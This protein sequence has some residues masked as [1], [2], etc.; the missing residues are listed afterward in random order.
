MKSKTFLVLL[1]VCVVLALASLVVF[2]SDD[3]GTATTPEGADFFA[4]LPVNDVTGLTLSGP[5]GEVALA[6][7]GTVW[8][9]ENRYGYPADFDD[10]RAFILKLRDL[11]VGRAF[12]ADADSRRRLSLLPPDAEGADADHRGTRV[13][14]QT[15]DSGP[16][17]DLIIGA[18]RETDAGSGGHYLRRADG[19][20]V[21]LVDESFQ[22]LELDP[23]QWLAPDL[24]DISAARVRRVTCLNAATGQ[25]L[26]RIERPEKG[27]PPVFVDPA[28][29]DRTVATSKVTNLFSALDNLTLED[30]ANP[31]TEAREMGL[32]T[33]ICHEFWLF[34]GTT[35]TVCKGR[36]LPDEENQ[37]Y[38][39]ATAG[40]RAP[41]EP[42]PAPESD[43]EA[44]D[45]ADAEAAPADGET[46]EAAAEETEDAPDPAQVA[47]E[48]EQKNEALSK[49]TF[50][51]PKWKVG[52]LVTDV[53]EFFET[54]EA[55]QP[56]TPPDP[57]PATPPVED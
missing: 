56:P 41:P 15:S 44:S 46:A 11:N 26:Y 37:H 16:A 29:G 27:Q 35:H 10:I 32:E 21:F 53:A 47:A 23:A 6:K 42:E 43:G 8:R 48:A 2:Q 25:E 38:L 22:F 4:N 14:L 19:D 13:V 17:A 40:Y 24:L 36:P 18:A 7:G 39:R 45:A 51:V 30:V 33:P 28:P 1:A 31:E 34:D 50:V 3:D 55:A 12:A 52:R 54:P 57:G 5:E 9:V 20:T 49:W